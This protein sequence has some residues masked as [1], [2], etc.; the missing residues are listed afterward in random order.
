MRA[1]HACF[2]NAL[3]IFTTLFSSALVAQYNYE[4]VTEKSF[5]RSSL[6]FTSHFLNTFGL[7]RYREVSV[8][9]I[10]DPF[11]NLQLN[12]ASMPDIGS[13]ST[14][15]YLDFR[16]DRTEA[17]IVYDYAYY[18]YA[19]VGYDEYYRSSYF[20]D[21]RWYINTR[22]EPEPVFSLGLLTHPFG[23]NGNRN[24]LI[25]GSY[26]LIHRDEP[27]YTVPNW[28]YANQRGY[29]SFGA[30]AEDASSIPIIDR[31]F[32][33]D[34]MRISGHLFSGIAAY[35]LSSLI[36]AGISVNGV[37]Q[38]RDGI[39]SNKYSNNYNNADV[40]ASEYSNDREQTYDHFDWSGG[41]KLQLT[42]KLAF[43]VKGGILNGNADQAYNNYNFYESD[44]NY[45]GAGT[46]RSE[47]Y[48]LGDTRQ[49]WDQDGTTRYGRIYFSY[50]VEPGAQISG[51]FRSER[52]EV[53]LLNSSSINDTS[54]SFYHWTHDYSFY[55]GTHVSSLSDIRSGSGDREKTSHQAALNFN[56][57]LTPK[58]TLFGGIYVASRKNSINTLEAVSAN[59]FSRGEWISDNDSDEHLNHVIEDKTL[60]WQYDASY[61]TVQIPLFTRFKLN[62][63]WG[64]MLGVNRILKN[65]DIEE[66]TLAVFD[67]RQIT[68][69]DGTT[70]ETNFGERYTQPRQRITEE[71]TDVITSFDVNL[72]PQFGISLLLDP[73]FRDNFRIAQWWLGFH[74]RL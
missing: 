1:I 28:I 5:E 9:I 71:Y 45:S 32:G 58:N 70:I 27:F 2:F 29:D 10:D 39:Y 38:D 31:S 24:L 48:G 50:Q 56:W 21:P 25:G 6:F 11:L 17:P 54:Y 37:L 30:T 40:Y 15:V 62:E 53:D 64:F 33:E 52:S 68:D 14:Y 13:K 66:Q 47:N 61:W 74:T 43:G 7:P 63:N 46:N 19:T 67:R 4:S 26:Q 22:T 35:Q 49:S 42:S 41:I 73:E 34:E 57:E 44:Y 59:R 3:L 23:K 60:R 20:I 65:W 18:D 36:S 69:L 12:P 51:F 55:Q 72:S 8:G 16:G